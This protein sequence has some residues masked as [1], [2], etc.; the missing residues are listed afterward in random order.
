MKLKIFT[1]KTAPPTRRP[2]WLPSC[3]ARFGWH[4]SCPRKVAHTAC[5]YLILFRLYLMQSTGRNINW[6]PCVC[7]RVSVPV[8]RWRISDR[9]PS[10]C[11]HVPTTSS[12]HS[13][14]ECMQACVCALLTMPD[15]DDRPLIRFTCCARDP[16]HIRK[17]HLTF[18]DVHTRAHVCEYLNRSILHTVTNTHTH[19]RTQ[20]RIRYACTCACAH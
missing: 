20:I 5:T 3:L 6:L 12:S 10:N 8:T 14:S 4:V 9:A 7:V 17:T 2:S 19:T 18:A 16:V 13:H 11:A 15:D 1:W